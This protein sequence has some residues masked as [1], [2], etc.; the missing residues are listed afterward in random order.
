MDKENVLACYYNILSN[1]KEPRLLTEATINRILTKHSNSG[2]IIV[3]ANRTDKTKKENDMHRN[4]EVQAELKNT[5]SLIADIRKSG[6]SYFPVYG[7]YK[8]MDGMVDKYE[9]SFF[10]TNYKGK[11]LQDNFDK[12]FDLGV[13]IC[14]KYNQDSVLVKAP[15]DVPK[16]I[17]RNGN[18]V[19]KEKQ[20][21]N[22][23]IN[24]I[25]KEYFTAL[26]KKDTGTK[27]MTYDMDFNMY[28]N[29]LPCTLN[30]AMRRQLSNEII[31][32]EQ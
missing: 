22:V 20:N 7:G 9:P 21:G 18:V 26:Y 29:P 2:F 15:N 3:S 28:L 10:I 12:L 1:N 31:M 14:N 6:Y 17:D 25:E 27:R 23:S 32:V 16:Y 4:S 5:K 19:G 8:G 13:K 11:T 24:R 30:E